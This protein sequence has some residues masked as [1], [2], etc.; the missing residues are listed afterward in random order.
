MT[1]AAAF[2]AIGIKEDNQHGVRATTAHTRGGAVGVGGTRC[3]CFLGSGGRPGDARR[4]GAATTAASTCLSLGRGGRCGRGG[5]SWRTL[6][7]LTT[8]LV[9]VSLDDFVPIT[10]ALSRLAW[11]WL[12]LAG[13]TALG[14]CVSLH[15]L[16]LGTIAL[17]DWA[18]LGFALALAA[19][20]LGLV[21]GHDV[22]LLASADN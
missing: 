8:V 18:W 7:L 14:I 20:V 19:S 4:C 9:G 17:W 21:P 6:A 22:V 5:G 15:N 11:P 2:A 13:L 3:G 1:A 12:A 10:L 16:I